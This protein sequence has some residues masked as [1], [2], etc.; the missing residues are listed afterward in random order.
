MFVRVVTACRTCVGCAP[1]CC[2]GALVR[3]RAMVLFLLGECTDRVVGCLLGPPFLCISVSVP[4]SRRWS[5]WVRGSK[6]FERT[7]STARRDSSGDDSD[8]FKRSSSMRRSESGPPSPMAPLPVF[9]PPPF[10][11]P[12]TPPAYLS[13]FPPP[14]V[15][16]FVFRR[17]HNIPHSGGGNAVM[18]H[19]VATPCAQPTARRERARRGRA[20][21]SRSALLDGMVSESPRGGR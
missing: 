2:D 19:R 10:L 12:S 21:R 14:S 9:S 7:L 18:P 8:T 17:S 13:P 20:C 16:P 6:Q 1:S 3:A 5:I 15:P 4:R 11:P